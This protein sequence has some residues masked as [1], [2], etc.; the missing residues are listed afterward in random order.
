MTYTPAKPW[1]EMKVEGYGTVRLFYL[2]Q[3]VELLRTVQMWGGE[4]SGLTVVKVTEEKIDLEA[5]TKTQSVL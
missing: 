3:E 2:G 4:A 1:Y 5:L